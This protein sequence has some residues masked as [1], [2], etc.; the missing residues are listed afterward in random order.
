MD[1]RAQSI[2]IARFIMSLIVGAPIV[3][4]VWRITDPILAGAQETTDVNSAN[5]A[6]TW[7]QQGTE[8][9]PIAFMLI[10]FF[11]IIVYAVYSRQVFS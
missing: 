10:A 8:Y 7:F 5:Q 2:G 4:I 9:L 1:N 3:W 11:G 6:T